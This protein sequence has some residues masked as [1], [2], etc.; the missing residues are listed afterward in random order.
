MSRSHIKNFKVENF[1]RFDSLEVKDMGQ[2]NLITGDN[3]VGK[4]CLMEA[5]MLHEEYLSFFSIL[6]S[7]A[8]DRKAIELFHY[9]EKRKSIED[10]EAHYKNN[11][12]ALFLRNPNL[13]LRYQINENEIIVENHKGSLYEHASEKNI[14]PKLFEINS[15]NKINSKNWIIYSLNNIVKH[16]LDVTSS[17]YEKL[18]FDRD[19]FGIP[20]LY[21]ENLAVN[22]F[23]KEVLMDE[24]HTKFKIVEILNTVFKMEV[25]DIMIPNLT[26]PSKED[27]NKIFIFTNQRPKG[28]V[29]NDYGYGFVRVLE[30]LLLIHTNFKKISIDEFDTGIH[31]SKLKE[32]W[33]Y[34]LQICKD[35]NIQLFATTHSQECIEAY[36]E[37]LEEL[38]MQ[39][40][41]RLIKLF[42]KENKA[43]KAVCYSFDEME[44]YVETNTEV[45]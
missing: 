21:L 16:V 10:V 34:V 19:R 22:K 12:L 41:G 14:D 26:D 27:Y 33:A 17:E 11:I 2:F 38:G 25:L 36:T 13:P 18:V 44:H 42:E 37:A 29:A 30:I 32:I 24:I 5:L 35:R 1:K 31:Y 8:V 43:V 4:T 20:F 3:N 45:R 6:L 23:F 15:F 40:E 39:E 28:H 7:I 9:R